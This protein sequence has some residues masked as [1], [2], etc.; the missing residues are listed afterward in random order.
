[1]RSYSDLRHLRPVSLRLP[2]ESWISNLAFTVANDTAGDAPRGVDR[3]F[4]VVI[5]HSFSLKARSR[6]T[7]SSSRGPSVSHREVLCR[8]SLCSYAYSQSSLDRS[9]DNPGNEGPLQEWVYQQ[10]RQHPHDY[11]RGVKGTAGNSHE[12]SQCLRIVD[13]RDVDVCGQSLDVGLQRVVA[14]S[15]RVQSRLNYGRLLP[16]LRRAVTDNCSKW[17]YYLIGWNSSKSPHRI[18]TADPAKLYSA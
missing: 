9:E 3:D 6:K 18:C 1:M 12:L 14:R 8:N 7:R 17:R 2:V 15:P 11:L 10:N 13:V 4:R 16:V 5:E